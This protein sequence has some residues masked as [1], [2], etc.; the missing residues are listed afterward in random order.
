M[1][2]D[3]GVVYIGILVYGVHVDD[4]PPFRGV[5]LQTGKSTDCLRPS[6]YIKK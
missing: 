4:V 1:F 5:R 6:V 3:Y 2:V